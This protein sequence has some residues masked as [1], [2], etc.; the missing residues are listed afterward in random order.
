VKPIPET[1]MAIDELDPSLSNDDLLEQLTRSS[2][3]VRAVAPDVIGMSV[4]MNQQGVTLTLVASDEDIATLD[5]FQYLNGGP[6]VEAN[7]P[8]N[9]VETTRDDLFSE[10][11]WRLFAEASAAHAVRSTLT[12]PVVRRGRVIGT[13]NLYAAS[14]QAFGGHHAALAEILGGWAPGAVANADLSFSTRG[15]ARQ[16]PEILRAS[17]VMESAVGVLASSL[18]IGFREA[19]DRLGRAAEQAGVSVGRLATAVLALQFHR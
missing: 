7:D 10:A 6:C 3:Q 18:D 16:A 11:R 14:E 17:A 15:V 8:T 2:E 9:G 1:L 19:R 12:L 5:A 4:A 13:V